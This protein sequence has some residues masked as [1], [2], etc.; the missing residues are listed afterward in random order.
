MRILSAVLLVWLIIGAVAAGQRGYYS[1]S[2]ANCAGV[3]TIVVTILAG[4]LNY[5]GVNP[6]V[7]NCQLPQPSR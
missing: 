6:Q 1:S 7:K 5:V 4:P 2:P 3:G